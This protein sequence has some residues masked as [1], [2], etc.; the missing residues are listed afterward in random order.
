[1]GITSGA[2]TA[3][4]SGVP[5]LASFLLVLVRFV[6]YNIVNVHVFHVLISVL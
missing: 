6:L 2:A 1:M 4:P 5:E 3:Y